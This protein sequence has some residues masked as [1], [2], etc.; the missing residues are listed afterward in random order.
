VGAKSGVTTKITYYPLDDKVL[1]IDCPGLEDVR[2]ENS[3]KTKDF[4][5]KID[6][7]ILVVTGSV[8]SLQKA[9]Y[10][11]L[12]KSA[13]KTIVVLNKIDEWD[14]LEKSAF[15]EVVA[16]WKLVLGT[17]VLFPACTKGYD[18]KMR[19]DIPMNLRG[20]D[21]IRNEIFEF[22]QTEGKEILLARHLMNKEIK[23]H[24]IIHSHA[25]AAAATSAALG[26][27][28]IIGPVTGDSATL[29]AITVQMGKSLSRYVF[30]RNTHWLHFAMGMMQFYLGALTIKAVSSL[31]PLYGSAN[32]AVS[33][34]TVEVIGWA[35]Y[36]ILDDG[37]DPDKL[38]KEEFKKALDWAKKQ[39]K[40]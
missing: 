19:Q 35:A 3:A 6:L 20:V 34:A 5:K 33:V 2:N 10:D 15:E 40:G 7:G 9:N 30:N 29:I 12:K 14:D 13:K 38:S 23:A 36:R 4:F 16:Q 11:D 17:E 39:K 18:P 26:A 24:I 8:D 25:S 22:L 28:P 31:L 37:N 27:I 21:S 32:A 1:I